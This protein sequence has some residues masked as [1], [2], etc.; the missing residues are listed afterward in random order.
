MTT[1]PQPRPRS[2]VRDVLDQAREAD[3]WTPRSSRN[4]S[5]AWMM[6]QTRRIEA[7]R[8]E[9]EGRNKP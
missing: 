4:E 9:R 8:R 6:E 7:R 5:H 2:L 3:A 1:E